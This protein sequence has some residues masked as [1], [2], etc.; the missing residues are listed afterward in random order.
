MG[1]LNDER[2]QPFLPG[3][4][5]VLGRLWDQDKAGTSCD[6]AVLSLSKYLGSDPLKQ[7]VDILNPSTGRQPV[8]W[9]AHEQV[10]ELTGILSHL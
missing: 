8:M 6:A 1:D 9:A 10:T 4:F 3:D 5:S 7:P 2:V